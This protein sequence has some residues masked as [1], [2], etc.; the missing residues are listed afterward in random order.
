MAP[1]HGRTVHPSLAHSWEPRGAMMNPHWGR[2]C[3]IFVSMLLRLLC[4][5]RLTLDSPL[6]PLCAISCMGCAISEKGFFLGLPGIATT[7]FLWQESVLL[8]VRS[9]PG[10][11]LNATFCHLMQWPCG[12]SIDDGTKPLCLASLALRSCTDPLDR[13]S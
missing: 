10:E 8:T 12:H 3:S 7:D 1:L 13:L 9:A 11:K 4:L 5:H 6:A 2:E